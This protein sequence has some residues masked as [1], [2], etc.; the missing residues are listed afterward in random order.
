M[1]PHHYKVYD[2]KTIVNFN[3][4]LEQHDFFEAD[5]LKIT[6]DEEEANK[7]PGALYAIY[8]EGNSWKEY[9]IE[10]IRNS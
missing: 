4:P 1:T 7:V 10:L 8:T 9:K 3:M 5:L 2:P 6:Q